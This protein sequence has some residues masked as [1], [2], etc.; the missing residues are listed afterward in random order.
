M[1]PT[2][3]RRAHPIRADAREP[4]RVEA[5]PAS[6]EGGSHV[7]EPLPC[8]RSWARVPSFALTRGS[9]TR[10]LLVATGCTSSSAYWLGNAVA[11]Q[12]EIPPDVSGSSL[13]RH[14]VHASLPRGTYARRSRKTGPGSCAAALR[15]ARWRP[16]THPMNT[17]VRNGF[18][19]SRPVTALPE[20]HP[21]RCGAGQ[22]RMRV[23]RLPSER[24][25]RAEGPHPERSPDGRRKL[26]H[27]RGDSRYQRRGFAECPSD[28][29]RCRD[30]GRGYRDTWLVV[31]LRRLRH[32][33]VFRPPDSCRGGKLR[34]WLKE[35]GGTAK[36]RSDFAARLGG[37]S[38]GQASR[39]RIEQEAS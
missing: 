7:G 39:R 2:V 30:R 21:F 33:R 1:S 34:A 8:R 15:R 25:P 5:R 23:R 9:L 28:S 11:T 36:S 12:S 18:W 27:W 19:R 6:S 13:D 20:P 17:R 22:H 32:G 37:D 3:R 24:E 10:A 31:L 38:L 16:T 26:C 4:D 29:T 14:C 35:F